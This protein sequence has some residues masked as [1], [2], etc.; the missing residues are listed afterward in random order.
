MKQPLEINPSPTGDQLGTL[1]RDLALILGA[2]PALLAVLGTRDFVAVVTYLRSAEF[3]PVAGVLW[4]VAIM[5]WRQ[6][7]AR[8]AKAKLVNAALTPPVDVA[9]KAAS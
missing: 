5:V 7:I 8:R 1:T 2:I 9:L 6:L 4:T 3:A